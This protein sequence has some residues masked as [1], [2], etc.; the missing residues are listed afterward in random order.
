MRRLLTISMA[1]S[2]AL[3]L[4]FGCKP[5]VDCDKLET[6]LISCMRENYKVLNP[7]GCPAE[8]EE[9]AKTM[10]KLTADYAKLVD[11]EIVGPCRA[12]DGRDSRASRINQ[13]LDQNG[14]KEVHDC[15]KKEAQ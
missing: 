15:L 2:L 11:S 10:E 6:R 12:K 14:C 4:A 13:C 5:K 7:K 1:F 8:A 3:P 9:C